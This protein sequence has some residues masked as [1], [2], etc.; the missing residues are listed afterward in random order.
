MEAVGVLERGPVYLFVIQVGK[1]R[2]CPLGNNFA[3]VCAF[4]HICVL[5]D[6]RGCLQDV[7]LISNSTGSLTQ[8]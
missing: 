5:Q 3:S 2:F 8:P 7:C 6:G 1:L 4:P